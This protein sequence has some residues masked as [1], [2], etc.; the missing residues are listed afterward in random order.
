MI[1]QTCLM[2]PT[3]VPVAVMTHWAPPPPVEGA[4]RLLPAGQVAGALSDE[5]AVAPRPVTAA[6]QPG[7]LSPTT[8]TPVAA[9]ATTLPES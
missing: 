4:S 2:A 5:D 8:M 9:R 1:S 6:I 3:G 7:Q